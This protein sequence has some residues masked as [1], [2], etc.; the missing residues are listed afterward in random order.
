MLPRGHRR[1]EYL[2]SIFHRLRALTGCDSP[3]DIIKS[4]EHMNNM[5]T[6]L[7]AE[8]RQTQASCD[9]LIYSLNLKVTCS[10]SGQCNCKAILFA[11]LTGS[12]KSRLIVPMIIPTLLTQA[13]KRVLIE[14]LQP[15]QS[16]LMALQEHE[17]SGSGTQI[18][19]THVA[20]TLNPL[21]TSLPPLPQSLSRTPTLNRAFST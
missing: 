3:E 17:E 19:K 4:L 7:A 8:E 1:I 2:E 16:I 12:G 6:F 18:P 9:T 14:D 11:H 10:T 20:H 13:R 15:C 5:A 21:P